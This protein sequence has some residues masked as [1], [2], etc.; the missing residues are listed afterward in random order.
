MA[1]NTDEEHLDTPINDLP[2][3]PPDEIISTTDTEM[4]IPTQESENMEVH[5]HAHHEGKKNWKSYFWE[6]LMLFLAVFCGFLAEYQLEHKIEGERGKQYVHSFYEDL[7]HD[8]TKFSAIINDFQNKNIALGSIFSCFDSLNQNIK[9]TDCLENLYVNS[10][11]F[12]DFEYTDRTIQQLKNAGGL[13]LLKSDDANSVLQFDNLIREYLKVETSS[14]QETQTAV[15]N[16][17]YPIVNFT[18]IIDTAKN[19]NIPFLYEA[20]RSALN[21][22]FNQLLTYYSLTSRQL[23]ALKNI[24]R[25]AIILIEYFKHKYNFK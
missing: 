19:S 4:I 22:L 24:Y 11:G 16:S 7:V 20:D 25:E 5:H 15:R 12:F 13:R 8:T 6:F 10:K 2:E 14:F 18:K 23:H 9:S 1:D 17:F 3:N 21:K